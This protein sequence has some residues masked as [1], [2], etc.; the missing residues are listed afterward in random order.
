MR[1]LR[2]GLQTRPD[3]AYDSQAVALTFVIDVSGSM[4][5]P[6]KLDLVKG[7]LSALVNNLQPDDSVAIVTFNASAHV[8]VPTMFA[9]ERSKLLSAIDGLRARGNT[10]LAAGLT[11]GYRVAR[12]GFQPSATNRVVILSD[13]LAN[14][15]ETSSSAIVAQVSAEANKQITLLGVGVGRTYGDA[16]MEQLADHADGFVVYVSSPDQAR[17][18]F[19]EQLAATSTVRALDAKAQVTFNSATV[20]SYRLIGYDDRALANSSFTNDRVDGGEVEAGQQVTALYAVQLQP[21]AY[22]QIATAAVR[23][24]DPTTHLPFEAVSSVDVSSLDVP[25]EQAAGGL[26][27]GYAA[28]FFAE[29][30]RGSPYGRSVRLADLASIAESAANVT[31]YPGVTDLADTIR[32]ASELMP[33]R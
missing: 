1:L 10:N 19:L 21:N 28:A 2:V 30:L 7:A 5:A 14:T 25:F 23:W 22:G 12:A 26:R 32:R 16:L 4:G 18:V 9:S 33:G 17:Q 13:G 29:V 11:T 31:E 3:D 20:V 15:G 6:G 24:L 27:V 8:I